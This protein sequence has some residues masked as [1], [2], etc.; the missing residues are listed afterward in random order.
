MK[1]IEYLDDARLVQTLNLYTETKGGD[2]KITP[3][4]TALRNMYRNLQ[5]NRMIVPV[6]G[7]QGMGKS[8]L[9]NSILGKNIL[10]NDADETTCAPV[11]VCYDE[12]EYAEVFFKHSKAVTIVHTREELNAFVDNNE[13]PANKK[14]VS[15]I[16]LHD[17]LPLLKNGMVIVDLP[18]VGSLTA[19]NAETTNNYIKNL[20]TAIFVIPTTPTIRNKEAIFIKAVWS[21]FPTAVFVQNLW[22]ESDRELKESVEYNT[23]MLKKIAGEINTSY[24]GKIIVVNAYDALAGALQH[25][26]RRVRE[27]NLPELISELTKFSDTWENNMYRNM[28][29]RLYG[30]IANV[31][32]IIQKRLHEL[33][34]SEAEIQQEREAALNQFKEQ[35]KEIR[36][37]IRETEE[38]LDDAEDMVRQLAK[39]KSEECTSGIRKEIYR[40]IDSGIT[41]GSQLTDAFRNFQ[42]EYIPETLNDM[43]DTFR[44]IKFELDGKLEELEAI[45]FENNMNGNTFDFD[46]G[47]AF[48]FEKSFDTTGSILGGIGGFVLGG[49]ASSALTAAIGAEAVTLTNPV[50][51]LPGLTLMAITA[52]VGF[53][54]AALGNKAKKEVTSSRAEKTKSELSDYFDKIRSGVYDTIVNEFDQIRTNISDTLGQLKDIRK[55]QQA[56]LEEEIYSVGIENTDDRQKL[57]DDLSYLETVAKE[58]AENA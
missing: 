11:E 53:I 44:T 5:S 39:Q 46:N 33:D 57:K 36:G 28:C 12:K 37:K 43:F 51:L 48:K 1:P 9:I 40:L 10:P 41:D 21:Q 16:I 17:T 22:D 3:S 31:R 8:T 47:D 50:T 18:G 2:E 49:A 30:E 15:K 58:L 54:G 6:L 14:Q 24:D 7:M 38:Y 29:G 34:L 13:N 25:D 56:M 27:A 55:K 52:V 23:L 26:D 4:G 45:H 19:E 32:K 20:C 35:T 42:E